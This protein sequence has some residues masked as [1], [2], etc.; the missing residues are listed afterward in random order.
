[1]MHLPFADVAAFVVPKD[2]TFG[3]SQFREFEAEGEVGRQ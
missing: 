3:N 1:M 2:G